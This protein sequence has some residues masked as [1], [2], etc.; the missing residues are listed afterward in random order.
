MLQYI[1]LATTHTTVRE[2]VR[3]FDAQVSHARHAQPRDPEPPSPRPARPQPQPSPDAELRH[4]GNTRRAGRHNPNPQPEP[5]TLP[6][7]NPQPP[8]QRTRR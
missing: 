2:L 1:S 6:T 7:R 4:A 3:Q 8:I 5:T